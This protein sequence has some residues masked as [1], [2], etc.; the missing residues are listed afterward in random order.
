M[1]KSCHW[2][3]LLLLLLF[4]L[5]GCGREEE[6]AP[7]LWVVTEESESDGMNVQAL[8]VIQ[9]FQEEQPGVAVTLDILPTDSVQRELRLKQLRTQIMA[10]KG[11]DVYLLPSCNAITY[12][13]KSWRVSSYLTLKSQIE[14]LFLDPRQA[15]DN[16]V[17]LDISTYYDRD[18]ALETEKLQQTVM[19]AGVLDGARCLLPLRYDFPVLFLDTEGVRSLG[20]EPESL[21]GSGVA[22]MEAALRLGQPLFAGGAE[23]SFCRLGRGF[24]LLPPVLDYENGRVCLTETDLSSFL[25][26]YQALEILAAGNHDNRYGPSLITYVQHEK[27][28]PNSTEEIPEMVEANIFIR[29]VPIVVGTL[30]LAPCAAA[31]SQVEEREL[32]MIP[33][34]SS[35]G[36]VVAEVT[37]YGAVGAGC[38]N[39]ELAYDF[40]RRFLLEE[41]QWERGRPLKRD[42]LNNVALQYHPIADGW[43]VRNRGWI[44]EA[45]K[46]LR[47]GVSGYRSSLDKTFRR[48][49]RIMGTSLTEEDIPLLD[50]RIDRV[51]FGHT[52]EQ[53]LAALL[54]ELDKGEKTDAELDTLA[55]QFLRELKWQ[56]MEG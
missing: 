37:Y 55:A 8:Q 28:D 27:K 49:K 35:D 42:K 5:G 38:K 44:E 36:A 43:P 52:L 48:S 51:S 2:E 3:L 24:S 22:L 53:Q 17:F 25:K 30:S 54:R 29:D 15:M 10:G 4:L 19:D 7:A 13:E 40:L 12:P 34:R 50:V 1:K 31:I 23:P 6:A 39:P 46:D 14:P 21:T 32:E 33:L 16:G 18:E 45:W 20:V 47:N 56:L 11:P 26:T 41:N 9:A